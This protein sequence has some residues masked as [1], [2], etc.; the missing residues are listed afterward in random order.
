MR[1]VNIHPET[2][3]SGNEKQKKKQSDMAEKSCGALCVYTKYN[4]FEKHLLENFITGL[5][6]N[7]IDYAHF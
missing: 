1:R 6:P 3:E 4:K 7:N 2:I 5:M